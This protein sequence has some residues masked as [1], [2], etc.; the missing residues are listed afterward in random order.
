MKILAILLAIL[1]PACCMNGREIP[2]VD[3][4]TEKGTGVA[5]IVGE[6]PDWHRGATERA[7]DLYVE[8][9][10]YLLALDG[11]T[12]RPDLSKLVLAW[13]TG[14][15]EAPGLVDGPK[16]GITYEPCGTD[17]WL[18][19]TSLTKID[20]IHWDDPQSTILGHEMGHFVTGICD[21]DWGHKNMQRLQAL[22]P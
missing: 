17:L 13:E 4:Y 1:L 5:E 20:G 8:Y 2:T 14:P 7:L 21:E 22:A 12:C 9:W 6:L 19:R 15:V 3:W 11:K 16:D 18:I 10:T